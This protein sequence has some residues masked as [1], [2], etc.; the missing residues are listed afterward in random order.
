MEALRSCVKALKFCATESDGELQD[1]ALNKLKGIEDELIIIVK[2]VIKEVVACA[3]NK[4]KVTVCLI[5]ACWLNVQFLLLHDGDDEYSLLL[6][7]IR[8]YELQLS[9]QIS[10]ESLLNDP[11]VTSKTFRTI[12]DEVFGFLMHVC[13]L[14][15]IIISRIARTFLE[16]F[17]SSF[18][19][20]HSA[21]FE[22][23]KSFL[24]TKSLEGLRAN[25]LAC[26][27]IFSNI[28]G[29]RSFGV[30]SR[31]IY[32]PKVLRSCSVTPQ[33]NQLRGSCPRRKE[34][35]HGTLLGSWDDS[36]EP[37]KLSVRPQSPQWDVVSIEGRGDVCE[38]ERTDPNHMKP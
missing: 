30:L 32:S 23:L 6:N 15:S 12:D 3:L 16:Q 27:V 34:M 19:S 1:F 21:L 13:W 5:D 37:T 26:C 35:D 17:I 4:L 24:T 8:L 14:H 22:L 7:L 31:L 36:V 10:I 11:A 2:S 28:H 18:I 20:K 9:R 25:Q 38:P 33:K 29:A